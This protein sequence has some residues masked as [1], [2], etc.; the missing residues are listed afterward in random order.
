MTPRPGRSI[1]VFVGTDH[2]T[3]GRLV[4]WA[5]R[6]AAANPDDTV[7]VQYGHSQPPGVAKG[8]AFMP[9]D[10]LQSL[11]ASSDI[12]V[13][14]GGPATIADARA[15]GH[16]PLVFPRDPKHGE[17]VDDH[18]QRFSRWSGTRELVI[19]VET[20]DELGNRVAASAMSQRG[21]RTL[22]NGESDGSTEAAT[23]LTLLL[24]RKRQQGNKSSVGAPV[25]L[26]ATARSTAQLADLS[27]DLGT[28]LNVA[29]VG[30]TRTVWEQGIL[31]NND[32]SC[33]VRFNACE[34]WQETGKMAFGGWGKV[35]LNSLLTLRT[36]VASRKVMLRSALKTESRGLRALLTEYSEPYYAIFSAVRDVSGADLVLHTD[37]DAY[38]ALALSHNREI[39]LRYL[40]LRNKTEA[41]ESSDATQPRRSL[42]AT[43]SWQRWMLRRRGIPEALLDASFCP[44]VPSPVDAIWR[45]LGFSQDPPK[46]APQFTGVAGQHI[47]SAHSRH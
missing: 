7:T 45:R 3:F 37:T 25:V 40:D 17:H 9:A 33:G 22:D 41:G 2:H 43:A 24:D 44:G 20:L 16:L 46:E 1:S 39:D 12:V 36:A 30:D 8:H 29:V 19:C 42:R 4:D 18:Q 38:L 15:A 31:R 10:Q 32:C 13:T 26:Y 6:W 5:D 27:L 35:D 47:I 21:T 23:Q 11:I 28:R 34:F 14:H